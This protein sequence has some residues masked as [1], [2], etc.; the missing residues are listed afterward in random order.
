MKTYHIIANPVAGKKKALKNLATVQD[1]LKKRG[2]AFETHISSTEKDV[3]EI[4]RQITNEGETELI[5]LGGDGTLHETLNGIVNLQTCRI[6]LI[7][8]GTG[9]D[10]AEHVALPLNAEK[11]LEVILDGSVKPT[12]YLEVGGVRCMNVAGLGMDVDVLERCKKGKFKGKIKY[13]CS[14]VQSLFAFK[15]YDIE[16]KINGVKEERKVLIGAVCNGSQFGGGIKICPVA[17][18]EDG[19][20]DVMTV[21]CIGGKWKLI[22]AFLVLM[23]GGIMEYPLAKH[24]LCEEVAFFPKKKCTAQLD[25][26]LYKDLEFVV[27]VKN[28]LQF[29]RP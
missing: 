28:G 8:S 18:S 17:N 2:V 14:L 12:D 3:T 5:V 16:I 1:L 22:K 15:G 27:K 19:K 4:V 20:L 29:Y 6:G 21:D 13:V 10:F 24:T 23:K 25:G 11:A 26:E 7:P 9:N